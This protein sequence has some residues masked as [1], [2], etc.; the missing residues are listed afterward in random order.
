[1]IETLSLLWT[2]SKYSP[3]P[4]RAMIFLETL[5]ALFTKGLK[6]DLNMKED[7]RNNELRL[8]F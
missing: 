6:P 5:E 7:F 3:R 4:T 1:M 2:T 8:K